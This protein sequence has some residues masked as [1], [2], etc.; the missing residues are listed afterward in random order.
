MNAMLSTFRFNRAELLFSVKAFAAAMLA[1]YLASRMGQ[2][3]P[4][5]AMMTAYIVASPLAGAVRS[6]A[7]FRFGGTLIGSTAAV[8]MVPALINSPELLTLGLA[9]WV[10]VC[11]YFSLLDRTP[12]SYL[13][14]L[15][16]YTAALI[17]FPAVDTPL[18]LFD[19]A[20][21]RVE[22]IGIGILCASLVHAVVLPQSLSGPVLGLLDRG[23]GDAR[24]WLLDLVRAP[25]KDL[26]GDRQRLAADLTQLRL[27]ATH[28]PFDTTHLRHAGD[29]VRAVQDQLAALTPALS[30]VE[31]RLQ[32]LQSAEGRLAPD[33]AAMLAA[34]AGWVQAPGDDG[35]LRRSLDAFI[36]DTSAR[37]AGW[38][39]AL[40]VSLA[41]RLGELVGAWQ[42]ALARR[43]DVDQ[44]LTGATAPRPSVVGDHAL[45]RDHGMALLSALAA[46]IAT[47]VCAAFWILSGWPTGSAAVMMAAIFCCF[48]ASMDDPVPAIH[49]FLTF[50]LWSVPISAVYVLFVLPAVRDFGMLAL[51][52]APVFLVL[53][54][55]MAR[56]STVLSAMPILMGVATTLAMHDTATADLASFANSITA[57]VVGVI[58]ASRTTRLMR[59]IGADWSARRIQQATWR[60]LAD[61]AASLR[62]PVHAAAQTVRLLDRIALIAP[63]V[64]QAG[65]KVDGLPADALHDLRL[66]TDIVTL[67][68]VRWHLPLGVT[69]A[70]MAELARWLRDLA[71]G[72]QAARPSHLLER[73]DAAL[74]A[75]LAAHHPASPELSA[76]LGALVGVRRALFPDAPAPAV[77]AR[78]PEGVS[79]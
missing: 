63:R 41:E 38:P 17:G 66:G 59:S 36:D 37:H 70:L 15:A 49:G 35:A 55:L 73:I 16:G 8:L 58:V 65:G 64:A 76:G 77:P 26:T 43:D 39:L 23:L 21:A 42:A 62:Q 57:Q 22:E 27:L 60:E 50:T 56:P 4:F 48:F 74:V 10:G 24:R 45:H 31:D 44:A 78:V 61:I 1:M 54:A 47:G 34:F 72:R 53:G 67:Q 29:A 79:S 3:R 14:M 20:V 11:L 5:W 2:P 71:A 52:C 25:A 68:R 46:V 13:F 32:A 51:A 12:R 9:L 18:Q 28:I 40:R 75:T 6:K 7:L 19:I 33:I 69:G 30:A